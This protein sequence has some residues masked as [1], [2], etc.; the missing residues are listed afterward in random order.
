M[1]EPMLVLM[2][3][4]LMYRVTTVLALLRLDRSRH[5]GLRKATSWQ[6]FWS[7][8]LALPH[9][10]RHDAGKARTGHSHSTTPRRKQRS[11]VKPGAVLKW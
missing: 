8:P 5:S 7:L 4:F 6:A 1:L 11:A 9:L 3:V 10:R 2:R